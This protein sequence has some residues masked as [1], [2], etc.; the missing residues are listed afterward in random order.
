[1]A[2][3]NINVIFSK[4][5]SRTDISNFFRENSKYIFLI[6][7]MQPNITHQ[8]NVSIGNFCLVFSSV[9][10]NSYHFDVSVGSPFHIKTRT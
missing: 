2:E 8:K 1:M 5:R 7:H 9:I 3:T 6:L 4:L 10:K